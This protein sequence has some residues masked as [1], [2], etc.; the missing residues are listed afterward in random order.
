LEEVVNHEKSIS[1]SGRDF[2]V[3]L[4]RNGLEGEAAW[5][6]YG[7]VEKANSVEWLL[8]KHRLRPRSLWELGCGT[9]AIICE[10]QR[11]GVA[12]EYTA[13]DYS[14]DAIN[15]LK[16][17]SSGINCVTADI[18][19][20][21]F[22]IAGDVDV[23]VLSHVIE[24]LEDPLSI[25]RSI[26]LR[27]HPR[28]IVVEVPLE[29]LWF[30]RFKNLFRDRLV[31]NTGHVQ[32]YTP[33]SFRSCIEEGGWRIIDQRRYIPIL[34]H[35]IIQFLRKKDNLSEARSA[36]KTVGSYLSKLTY[37]LWERTYYAHYAVLCE[38]S[39]E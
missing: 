30:G 10:L 12:Q 33:S 11:R 16:E 5:L 2:Y 1:E 3:S 36:V 21:S 38:P 39:S 18:T 15:Y 25:L 23:V 26:A 20:P 27:V 19:D 4:Y 29:D 28:H 13:I 37:P 6:R 8:R 7:A 35:E 9:G 14:P 34:S 22:K 31:S 32:F 17:T 24:H